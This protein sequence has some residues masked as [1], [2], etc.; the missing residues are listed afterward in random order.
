MPLPHLMAAPTQHQYTHPSLTP[1]S[2]SSTSP[3]VS[4]TTRTQQP[5][6]STRCGAAFMEDGVDDNLLVILLAMANFLCFKCLDLISNSPSLQSSPSMSTA[7]RSATSGTRRHRMV[8]RVPR[9]HAD[10]VLPQVRACGD[11]ENSCTRSIRRAGFPSSA[12]QDISAPIF[13][14]S[15]RTPY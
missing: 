14:A 10:E 7:T 11:G 5:L 9:E 3:A 12:G 6:P 4:A 2:A 13:C 8:L 15:N 1:L